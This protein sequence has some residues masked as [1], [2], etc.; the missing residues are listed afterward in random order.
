MGILIFK[1]LTARRLYKSFGVK[2]LIKWKWLWSVSRWCVLICYTMTHGQQNMK[3]SHLCNLYVTQNTSFNNYGNIFFRTCVTLSTLSKRKVRFT[4]SKA[5]QV[6]C[7]DTSHIIQRDFT[8]TC[9]CTF[10]NHGETEAKHTTHLVLL[11]HYSWEPLSMVK[12][13]VNCICRTGHEGKTGSRRF[14]WSG[15]YHA[16][17]RYPRTRARTRP[18]PSNFSDEGKPQPSFGEEVKPS[19]PSRRFAAC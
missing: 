13:K 18:K 3:F 1:G 6:L 2:E 10:L 19:V 4:A 8:C 15:G 9:I 12:V 16:G 11:K 17:L 5:I 7:I 14:R